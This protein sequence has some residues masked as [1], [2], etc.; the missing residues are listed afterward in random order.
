VAVVTA[1]VEFVARVA[2][3]ALPDRAP[4]KVVVVS[5]FVLGWKDKPL[6]VSAP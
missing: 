6:A 2:V 1:L 5:V 4:E 3:E